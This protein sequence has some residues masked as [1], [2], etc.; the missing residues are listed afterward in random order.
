[1]DRI[2]RR[3]A[4]GIVLAL[5]LW[6]PPASAEVA[7]LGV[8]NVTVAP[9]DQDAVLDGDGFVQD[10]LP[11]G[12]PLLPI[13]ASK[14][15][16][17]PGFGTAE[18]LVSAGAGV[19]KAKSTAHFVADGS[20]GFSDSFSFVLAKE[21]ATATSATLPDGTPVNIAVS[22]SFSGSH[23][24]PDSGDDGYE[25]GAIGALLVGNIPADVDIGNLPD[26]IP[27]LLV[28][29]FSSFD[30]S[31]NVLTGD[32]PT[33]VGASYNL[34]YALLTHAAV[35]GTSGSEDALADFSKSLT[36]GL[37]PR[38]SGV[39]VTTD[40]GL[41]FTSSVPEPQTWLLLVAGL[42]ALAGWRRSRSI[43]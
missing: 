5:G 11:P 37:N 12:S 30:P 35:Y 36:F 28:L 32:F 26:N 33:T 7:V 1:M 29:T 13:T 31:L 40:S 24:V 22:L 9:V 19:L 2:I 16:A 14:S 27:G 15:V 25:A 17:F 38:T 42:A 18:G 6:V 10:H 39:T 20:G 21:P 8:T 23:S 41:V 4:Y 43:S 3:I 34:Y